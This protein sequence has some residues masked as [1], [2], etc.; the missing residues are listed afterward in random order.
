MRPASASDPAP[1][2]RARASRLTLFVAPLVAALVA[3][4]S[5]TGGAIGDAPSKPHADELGDGERVSSV[6]GPATWVKPSDQMSET[7]SG[8]PVDHKVYVTGV[9]INAIDTFD[10][11]GKG[12]RGN[13][14]VQ[15][16]VA[17]PGPYSGITIFGPSFSPP[18]LRLAQGD[19]ADVLG[20]LTEFSGPTSGPF[21]YCRT[22]PEIGGT[23]SFR[24]EDGP[25]E[26][27]T[28]PLSDLKS[29]DKARQWLGM[30][31]RVEGVSVPTDPALSG[32]RF[33]ADIDVGGGIEAGDVPHITNDL[34]DI[35]KNGPVIVAGTTFKSVTGII[36]Y[37]YGFKLAPRS[38]ADFEM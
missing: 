22:L 9:T 19:V 2:R 24:F 6:V 28:I 11:T 31:V 21:P 38:P 20:V 5:G 26:P 12:A 35:Q 3:G 18:D 25:A 14:Y 13:F 34:Y 10:E 8:K 17:K 29:Y 30:L 15:D 36:T 1:P 32:G 33:S 16:A 4:C 7:C 23:M 37:F 27:I